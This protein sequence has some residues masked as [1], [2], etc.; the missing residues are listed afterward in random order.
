MKGLFFSFTIKNIIRNKCRQQN[1]QT[2]YARH[3]ICL[4][5][6]DKIPNYLW[7]LKTQHSEGLKSDRRQFGIWQRDR[8]KVLT[9]QTYFLALRLEKCVL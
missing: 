5:G 8:L 1:G 3:L 7:F 2:N 9:D 4:W 6:S